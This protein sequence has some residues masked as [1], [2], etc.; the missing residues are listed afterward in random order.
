MD[1]VNAS[2]PLS[3]SQAY[4][5]A[6]K[7]RLNRERYAKYKA[8]VERKK[9]VF[10]DE[11]EKTLY[12]PEDI[13]ALIA[14]KPPKRSKPEEGKEEEPERRGSYHS[15]FEAEDEDEDEDED[16][17]VG[18]EPMELLKKAM[19]DVSVLVK[20]GESADD[21]VENLKKAMFNVLEVATKQ[22]KETA[23]T[24][25]K[26]ANTT[27]SNLKDTHSKNFLATLKIKASKLLIKMDPTKVGTS[28]S[29]TTTTGLWPMLKAFVEDFD[30]NVMDSG[31]IEVIGV[32]AAKMD[33]DDEDDEDDEHSETSESLL[34]GVKEMG[35]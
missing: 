22:G 26:A 30:K 17:E 24:A 19:A 33:E 9:E 32:A 23:E 35:K 15:V 11:K 28:V 18:K 5:Q 12:V 31:N 20:D 34:Q 25:N 4:Y 29:T 27:S 6:N 21:K 14:P 7:E 13:A 2:K 10:G 3:R 1:T 8:Q 16:I